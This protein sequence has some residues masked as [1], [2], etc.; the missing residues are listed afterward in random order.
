MAGPDVSELV[1]RDLKAKLASSPL[2]GGETVEPGSIYFAKPDQPRFVTVDLALV[3]TAPRGGWEPRL[4]RF[5]GFH[6]LRYV[7]DRFHLGIAA[8]PSEQIL[9]A[10]LESVQRTRVGALSRARAFLGERCESPVAVEAVLFMPS[11]RRD[12]WRFEITCTSESHPVTI[13]VEE[14]GL[15]SIVSDVAAKPEGP[16]APAWLPRCTQALTRAQQ[17]LT[18]LDPGFARGTITQRGPE[19]TNASSRPVSSVRFALR[20]DDGTEL[21]TLVSQPLDMIPPG[22]SLKGWERLASQDGRGLDEG[23]RRTTPEAMT[24]IWVKQPGPKATI[25]PK[26]AAAFVTEMKRAIDGCLAPPG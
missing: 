18:R 22:A 11:G 19:M 4:T 10:Q 14:G 8:A 5:A 17:A 26:A 6:E 7:V 21:E 13:A 9:R 15:V 1:R 20:G 16:P 12:Q 24:W 3:P 23:W 2:A 25:A